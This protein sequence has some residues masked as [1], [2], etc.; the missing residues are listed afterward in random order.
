MR[1]PYRGFASPA[2]VTTIVE[3]ALERAGL[4]PPCKGA[5][6]LRHSLATGLLRGGASLAEIGYI[7]R[8][9]SPTSTEI[10]AKVDLAGL[11][12]LAPPWPAPGDGR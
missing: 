5:H 4:H 8:H 1:A 3:R 7:L 11:R 9:R 2:A 10:Y 6:L 12:S